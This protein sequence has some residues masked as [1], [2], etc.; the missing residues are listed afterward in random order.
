M[1]I[2]GTDAPEPEDMG[3]SATGI[4]DS[5]L[6][7]M[8]VPDVGEPD[9]GEPDGGMPDERG[10]AGASLGGLISFY[11]VW[12]RNDA[13]RLVGGQSSSLFWNEEV[14]EPGALHEWPSW[15]GRFEELLE[16][17]Y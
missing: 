6:E 11:G 1:Q 10:L 12:T 15:R 4:D 8:G 9:A 14:E 7:D 3:L 2:D 17:L 13:F 5:G 16:F